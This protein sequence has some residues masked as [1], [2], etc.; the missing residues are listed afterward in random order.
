M[1]FT[2]AFGAVGDF[3]AVIALIKDIITALDD[4]RGSAKDYRDV[5]QALGILGKTVQQVNQIYD[6]VDVARDLNDLKILAI[7]SAGQIERCLK[8]FRDHNRK[9]KR[10]LGAGGAQHILQGVTRKIQWRFEEKDVTKFREDIKWY[11]TSLSMLLEVTT[12]RLMQ[13]NH[14]ARNAQAAD[15]EKRTSSATSQSVQTLKQYFGA[16]SQKIFSKLG[17]IAGIGLELQKSTSDLTAMMITLSGELGGIRNILMRLERPLNDEHFILEDITG[18][19]FPVHL[20]AITSWDALE[21]I[22]TDRFRGKRGARRVKGKK[23]TL[24]ERG[25][26]RQVDRS[27]DWESAFLPYQRIDMSLRC[28]DAQVSSP[29]AS[30]ASCPFCQTTSPEESGMEI[31][32]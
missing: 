24:Q 25:T 32:W 9:F 5:V 12:I 4:C 18:R 2:L 26:H 11:T 23:Y 28:L 15:Y 31:Q 10:S 29:N 7:S 13:R 22:L 21:Y 27:V 30:C 20:K 1:E 19:V 16:I 14:E 6:D 8:S 3:I 17:F